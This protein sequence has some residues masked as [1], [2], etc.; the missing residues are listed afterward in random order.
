MEA[1]TNLAEAKHLG[2][3]AKI[4]AAQKAF[5]ALQ[6]E[7]SAKNPASPPVSPVAQAK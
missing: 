5:D 4:A 3:Q 6:A 1:A 7:M 2:D